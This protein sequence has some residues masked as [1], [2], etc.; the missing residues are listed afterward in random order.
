MKKIIVFIGLSMMLFSCD[1]VQQLAGGYQLTQCKYEYNSISG[2]SLNGITT[3][4]L[5][6][7]LN[8]AKIT[9]A[10]ASPN[11]SFPLNF[12]LNLDVTNPGMQSAILNGLGY[13][14]EIDGHQMTTGSLS[15]KLQ[16]DGGQKTVLPIN[17]TFDL[18]QVLSGES[19]ESI[20]NIALSFAG[21]GSASSDVTVKLQPSLLIGNKVLNTPTYIPVSFKLNK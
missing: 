21:I 17:M 10:F 18:K 1:V 19:L 8:L 7:P 4:N 5:S 9:T 11:G 15:Q 14:L 13:I 6:N 3:Q 12:T 16:I 20:K 2:I